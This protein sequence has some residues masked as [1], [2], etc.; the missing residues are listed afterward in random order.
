FLVSCMYEEA[1]S[2]ASSVLSNLCNNKHAEDG[3]E[4]Q[5]DDMLESAG[6]VVVQ[7]LKELG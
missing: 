5:L 1:A 7:S 4:T 2:I 6:M 3:E